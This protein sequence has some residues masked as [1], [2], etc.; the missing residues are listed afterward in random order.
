MKYGLKVVL[1]HVLFIL[2]NMQN[3]KKY[4][5]RIFFKE[6]M[7]IGSVIHFFLFSPSIFLYFHTML[8]NLSS[9]SFPD[10]WCVSQMG[11][12]FSLSIDYCG[13]DRRM[14]FMFSKHFFVLCLNVSPG[15]DPFLFHSVYSNTTHSAE[16]EFHNYDWFVSP[17]MAANSGQ[18]AERLDLVSPFES[19]AV[20]I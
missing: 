9:H 16:L 7:F 6:Y 1:Y 4:S 10:H 12:S 17:A 2:K 18:S 20:L 5:I 14:I 11:F 8:Q 3:I 13:G 15:E 19:S